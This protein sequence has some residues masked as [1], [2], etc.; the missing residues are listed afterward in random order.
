MHP[1]EKKT[2][3]KNTQFRYFPKCIHPHRY[4]FIG[5]RSFDR[6][7]AETSHSMGYG[8]CIS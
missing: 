2:Q 4:V 7:I 8:L 6:S 3:I 5:V 1:G